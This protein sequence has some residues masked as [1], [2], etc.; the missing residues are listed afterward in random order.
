[1][2]N[3]M[4]IN[5]WWPTTEIENWQWKW[6][7]YQMKRIDHLERQIIHIYSSSSTSFSSSVETFSGF[8]SH[9][10]GQQNHLQNRNHIHCTLILSQWEKQRQKYQPFSLWNWI[11]ATESFQ[12]EGQ[13]EWGDNM[14]M[15][16]Y[17]VDSSGGERQA[18]VVYYQNKTNKWK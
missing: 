14:T 1:M 13:K 4:N 18:T 6:N 5:L 10:N 12:E 9:Q 11:R 16:S 8:R 3:L 15:P 2:S 7:C 17:I